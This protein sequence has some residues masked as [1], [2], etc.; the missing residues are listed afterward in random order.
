[1]DELKF[2]ADN[3]KLSPKDKTHCDLIVFNLNSELLNINRPA[4]V[5]GVI[6][7]H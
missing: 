3:Q 2:M 1:M 5:E 4:G 6:I 7:Y